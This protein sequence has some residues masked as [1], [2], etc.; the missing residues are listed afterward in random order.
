MIAKFLR[1]V[2]PSVIKPLHALWNQIIGF[3]FLCITV[4]AAFSSLRAARQ[5]SGDAE[6]LF[7]IMLPAFLALVMGFFCIT[8]FWKAR[9]ISRQ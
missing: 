2:V 4:F 3:L 7:H 1:F 6:G 8:S 5:F 9:K